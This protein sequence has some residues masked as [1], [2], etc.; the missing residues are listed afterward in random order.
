MG[1]LK[2]TTKVLYGAGDGGFSLILTALGAY[3]AVFLTDVVGLTPST[4]AMAIFLGR[5]WDCVNDPLLG[6]LTDRTR[7]RWGRRRPYLLFGTLPMAATYVMLWW[8][9]PLGSQIALAAYYSVAYLLFDTAATLVYMP[10]F[11]LTP[12]LTSDYD[13]RT[14]LTSWRMFFSIL[15]SLIAFPVPL[16]VA[17]SFRPENAPRIFA[18]GAGFALVCIGGLLLAF[19]GT[20]ERADFQAAAPP[21]FRASAGAAL[22]NKPFLFGLAIYLFTWLSVDIVQAV[23]IYYVKYAVQREAQSDILIGLIFLSAIPSLPLWNRLARAWDKR[24]AYVAGI[25]FW[26]VVQVVLT[27]GVG[28]STG[29]GL[30]VCLCV[31]AGVGVGAAHVL[32]WSILPDAVEWDEWSTGERH[33]GMFYSLVTL[34]QKAASATAVPLVLLALDASGYR[35]ASAEQTGDVVRAIRIVAGPVPAVL[36]CLGIA[37]ALLYPLSRESYGRIARELETRRKARAAGGRR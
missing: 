32:P 29:M 18:V 36:L 19:L 30:L 15:G 20:R 21:G 22:R 13:E 10:Y 24:Y 16:A 2:R 5:A 11:A 26:A 1:G 17:G 23:L 9:P 12:E 37:S 34:A 8:R 33:E 28:P 14:S 27:L 31:L 4:A 35:P 25:A 3:F 6:H 7:S